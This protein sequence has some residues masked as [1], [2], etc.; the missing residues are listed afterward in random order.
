[1]EQYSSANWLFII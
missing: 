1:M